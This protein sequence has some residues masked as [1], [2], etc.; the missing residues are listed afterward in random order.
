MSVLHQGPS[1]DVIPADA[2]DELLRTVR[3]G[4]DQ[5]EVELQQA[6]LEIV[7]LERELAAHVNDL[8]PGDERLGTAR[9]A[10]EGVAVG[11]QEHLD[12][13][14]AAARAHAAARVATAEADAQWIVQTA[15]EE[16]ARGL[17]APLGVGDPVP[18]ADGAP[19][20]MPARPPIQQLAGWTT[21][22]HPS[23]P[24]PP[25]ASL[26]APARTGP[27]L[28]PSSAPLE[29]VP[30]ADPAATNETH[31]ERTFW[32]DGD[33]PGAQAR[34]RSSDL[35]LTLAS[36]LFVIILVGLVLAWIG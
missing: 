33:S 30:P 14:V 7:Q 21:D 17:V 12:K 5:L 35:F 24:R 18:P 27:A 26:V 23:E 31:A 34:L 20:A 22:A 3:V 11:A 28:G 32:A 9:S 1:R 15:R 25:E 29:T 36:G 19:P 6:N 13:M 2:V 16:I 4:L 8:R 10:I